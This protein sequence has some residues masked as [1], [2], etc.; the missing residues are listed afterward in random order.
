M[1]KFVYRDT[2]E[3]TAKRL[4]QYEH[5]AASRKQARDRADTQHR[6]DRAAIN[7]ARKEWQRPRR[8]NG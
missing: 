3:G 2:S 5:I 6:E 4:R 8:R 7:Q 1:G